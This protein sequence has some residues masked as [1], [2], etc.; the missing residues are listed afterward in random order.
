MR[1]SRLAWFLVRVGVGVGLLVWLSRSGLLDWQ[2]VAALA[3]RPD[4]LALALAL[5][6]A[7]FAATAWRLCVLAAPLGVAIGFGASLRLLLIGTCFNVLMPG[8][9]GG[10]LARL[11]LA[12]RNQR[13]RRTELAVVL[14][15]DRISGL[16]GML[17][18]PLGAALAFP[19]AAGLDPA[20]GAVLRW[21][22]LL[23]ALAGVAA[24][25]LWGPFGRA[26]VARHLPWFPQTGLVARAA[27]ALRAYRAYPGAVVGSLLLSLL[28]TGLGLMTMLVLARVVGVTGPAALLLVLLP[29]GSLVNTIPLTPGGLGV[30]EVA[31]DRLFALAGLSGGA[32][33]LVS[34]RLVLLVPAAVGLGLY[35]QGRSDY[36]EPA[37]EPATGVPS[38]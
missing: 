8:A 17:L 2:R 12:L 20:L 24:L 38:G 6:A 1:A 23:A 21:T 22:A 26:W 14:L 4:A 36:V 27:T 13:G 33:T 31:M 28:A 35:L 19:H 29:I 32:V 37:G 25:L 7:G 34:W 18:V 5:V 3:T 30:G 15:F 10:D 9:A 11:Y 16:V